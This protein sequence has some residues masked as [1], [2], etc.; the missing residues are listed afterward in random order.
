[1]SNRP[2]KF[3]LLPHVETHPGDRHN[4]RNFYF[5]W[6]MVEA[7]TLDA[8]ALGIEAL[9]DHDGIR[10]QG[11]LTYLRF[12]LWILP[13]PESVSY[14]F[15]RR[16]PAFYDPRPSGQYEVCIGNPAGVDESVHIRRND[17]GSIEFVERR[18]MD[19]QVVEV[20]TDDR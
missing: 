3:R 15:W 2:F 9:I 13:F 12:F 8:P 1:M 20:P 18:I 11:F 10:L 16:P 17:D 14:W 4:T 5:S 19:L 7:W 6:L